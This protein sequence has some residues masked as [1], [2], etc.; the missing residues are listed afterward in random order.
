MDF[1][2]RETAMLSKNIRRSNMEV[3]AYDDMEP[4][5]KFIEIAED[6]KSNLESR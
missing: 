5:L 4:F 1:V 3:F 2:G 6:Q